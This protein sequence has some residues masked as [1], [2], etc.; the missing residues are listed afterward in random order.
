MM[1]HERKSGDMVAEMWYRFLQC[2][3]RCY[4]PRKK[5]YPCYRLLVL[6]HPL[7]AVTRHDLDIISLVLRVFTDA[8]IDCD[9]DMIRKLLLFWCVYLPHPRFWILG[10]SS[11]RMWVWS[12]L[13]RPKNGMLWNSSLVRLSTMMASSGHTTQPWPPLLESREC[14]QQSRIWKQQMIRQG[15]C[16]CWLPMVGISA[17]WSKNKASFKSLPWP[18]YISLDHP[19]L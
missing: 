4:I 12:H 3:P 2:N 6:T 16:K 19:N 13:A 5:H 9:L 8:N 14:N 1:A 15:N 17:A 7:K 10:L 11:H 18:L